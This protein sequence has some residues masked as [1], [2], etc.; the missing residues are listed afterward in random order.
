MLLSVLLQ[1]HISEL[2][3]GITKDV[4]SS[5]NRNISASISLPVHKHNDNIL[6]VTIYYYSN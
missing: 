1:V 2:C 6:K 4:T 5:R 3:F